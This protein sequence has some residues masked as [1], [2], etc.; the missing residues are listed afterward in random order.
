MSG[1]HFCDGFVVGLS[2]GF[3]GDAIQ[4]ANVFV[5]HGYSIEETAFHSDN[6]FFS[7]SEYT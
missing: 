4:V 3:T 5:G 6:C 7:S 2:Y 1:P